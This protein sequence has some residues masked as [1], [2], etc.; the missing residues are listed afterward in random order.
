[1]AIS[2]EI[3]K[4]LREVTSCG[5]ID[6]KKALEE[7]KGNLEEAKKIL[8]KKGLEIAQKK[9]KR[10]TSQG[11]IEAYVHLGDKLGVLLEVNCESD[12]VA[13]NED[14]KRFTRDVAMQIAASSPKYLSKDDVPSEALS[15][16]QD[17]ESFFKSSCLLEQPFIKDPAITIRDYLNSVIAKLGEN[18]VLRRFTRYQVGG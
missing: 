5:V 14:F 18:I 8:M 4:Q 7:S 11:R 13:R 2:A 12:F 15:K 1:M 3:I 6:C 10:I 17:K 16:E 9:A